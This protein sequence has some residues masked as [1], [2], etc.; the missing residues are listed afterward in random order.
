MNTSPQKN[1]DALSTTSS[2][3]TGNELVQQVIKE[4][5]MKAEAPLM[6]YFDLGEDSPSYVLGYN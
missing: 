3:I 5:V 4:P 1:E 2:S 6:R